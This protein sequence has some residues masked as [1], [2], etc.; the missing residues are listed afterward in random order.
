[1]QTKKLQQL[2]TYCTLLA[3]GIPIA[4]RSNSVRSSVLRADAM[5]A[6]MIAKGKVGE[7]SASLAGCAA[8]PL[9]PRPENVI[10]ANFQ[11][12]FMHYTA[13]SLSLSRYAC[14]HSMPHLLAR[15]RLKFAIICRSEPHFNDQGYFLVF[16]LHWALGL[17][18]EPVLCS[19]VLCGRMW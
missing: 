8:S 16:I 9:I 1:M 10:N 7:I 19:Q 12:T 6:T 4:R 3:L 18:D 2:Q 13:V 17:R 15:V 14:S 11:V 5:K